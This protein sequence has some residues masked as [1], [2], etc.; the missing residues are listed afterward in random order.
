MKKIDSGDNLLVGSFYFLLFVFAV[1]CIAP[2]WLIIASSITEEITLIRQGY[3]MLPLKFS[4]NAYELIFRTN[5][6]ANAYKVT[7]FVTIVGTFLSLIISSALAYSISVQKAKYRNIIAFYVYLTMLLNGGLVPTYILI[8]RYLHMKNSIW[9]LIIPILV[10]PWNMFL[11]RNFFKTIPES[12]AESAR[13]DGANDIFILFRIILPLSLPAIA[14]IGLFYALAYWNEWFRALLFIEDTSLFPLQYLI[15]K[16]LNSVSFTNQA[17]M[18]SEIVQRTV[19]PTFTARM[20]TAVVTIG[21]II[22]VYPFIQKY[23]IK[24]L[25]VGGVK[26]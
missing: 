3:R 17:F 18:P 25:T 15:M 24:G 26:G 10:N 22:F 6:I 7:I 12:L 14:T 9:V 4:F 8:S 2:F 11:L 21:P 23:F 16:I 20:A 1:L 5:T 19:V 13:I